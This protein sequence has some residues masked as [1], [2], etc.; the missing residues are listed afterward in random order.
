[1]LSLKPV[2]CYCKSTLKI[3]TNTINDTGSINYKEYTGYAVIAT[4]VNSLNCIMYSKLIGEYCFI[5]FRHF[6]LNF[7]KQDCRIAEVLSSSSAAEDRRPTVL[8]M[9]LSREE[10]S[11]DDLKI[12]APSLTLNYSTIIT[13]E[14]S[15]IKLSQEHIEY[16]K[17]L[18]ELI[19]EKKSENMFVYKESDIYN[20]AMKYLK[21][22][23]KTFEF[24]MQLRD[25]SLAYRY[26]KVGSKTDSIVRN[27]LL[28]RGHYKIIS[29]INKANK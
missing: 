13:S 17:I 28:S 9:L 15:L 29:N 23:V 22:K 25:V 26:N 27:I 16:R 20:I 5:M 1:M 12:I 8:R 21:D 10:L 2:G 3:N 7:G 19:E 14:S 4:P 11:D 18:D 6:K 24:I